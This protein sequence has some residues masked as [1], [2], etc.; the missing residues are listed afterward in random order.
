MATV[1]MQRM[2]VYVLP[3]PATHL[4]LTLTLELCLGLCG[5]LLLLLYGA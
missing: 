2:D 1:N 5:G 3:C 4:H